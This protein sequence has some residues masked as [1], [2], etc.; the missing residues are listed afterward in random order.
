MRVYLGRDPLSGRIKYH[1]HT[2]R[3]TKKKANDYARDTEQKRDKGQRVSAS[4]SKLTDY[5]IWAPESGREQSG[6]ITRFCR[7]L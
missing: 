6:T 5:L 7:Q 3:G 2:I 4:T 1:N